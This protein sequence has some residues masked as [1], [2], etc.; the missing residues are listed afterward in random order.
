MAQQ[1]SVTL[2]WSQADITSLANAIKQGV[3]S[4][5]YGT[6]RTTYRSLAEMQRLLDR[7]VRYVTTQGD[8]QPQPNF[9]GSVFIQR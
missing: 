9:R 3:L 2:P 4:V 5:D 1:Q 8:G 6:Y 7:M